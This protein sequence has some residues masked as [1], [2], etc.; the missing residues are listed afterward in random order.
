MQCYEIPIKYE[1]LISNEY[2]KGENLS[3]RESYFLVNTILN[4][5]HT[6]TSLLKFDDS[7][8]LFIPGRY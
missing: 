7:C 6:K 5:I 4:H 8:L 1:V 2:V 3:T